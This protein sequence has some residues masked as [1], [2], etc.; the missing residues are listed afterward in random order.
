MPRIPKRDF[1]VT[2]IM[3]NPRVNA[4]GN[5]CRKQ[6]PT[7]FQTRS[8]SVYILHCVM[9][10]RLWIIQSTRKK[11]RINLFEPLVT[12]FVSVSNVSSFRLRKQPILFELQIGAV[13]FSYRFIAS[14]FEGSILAQRICRVAVFHDVLE[15]V[16][17]LG[18]SRSTIS[19]AKSFR[20]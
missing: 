2:V 14:L 6:P 8:K 16:R 7:R 9:P 18:S 15:L 5:L 1:G 3:Y 19:P 17:S 10:V 4:A 20:L 12:A 13:V 11:L